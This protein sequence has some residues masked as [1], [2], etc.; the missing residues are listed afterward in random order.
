M[1][2]D[3]FYQECMNTLQTFATSL[4]VLLALS[5]IYVDV[6]VYIHINILTFI[7]VFLY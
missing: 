4:W 1:T 5:S 3:G 6:C 2:S 7:S